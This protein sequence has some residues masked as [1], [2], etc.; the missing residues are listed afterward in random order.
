MDEPTMGILSEFREFAIKGNFIDLAVG[1]ILG[2]ASGKVVTA[3]VE[4]IFMPP[5]GLVTG[6]VN[7]AE[8]KI[9]LQ[10]SVIGPD[11]KEIVKEV[12]LGY[13][14]ALQSFIELLLI[15]F[16]VFLVV[17]LYNRFRRRQETPPPTT[18]EKLLT[19]IRD[20]LKAQR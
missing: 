20:L 9:V 15:A 16:V 4:R 19:E 8:L 11:G 1:V 2:A 3:L 14:A 10:P 18:Q 5:V 17:R 7:F 6:R 13:G 12:A